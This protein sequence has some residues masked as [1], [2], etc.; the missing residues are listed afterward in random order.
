MVCSLKM[1]HPSLQ[2]PLHLPL[3][4]LLCSSMFNLLKHLLSK[5]L[6]EKNASKGNSTCFIEPSRCLVS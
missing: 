6:I 5:C 4:T 2:P 3:S 1:N